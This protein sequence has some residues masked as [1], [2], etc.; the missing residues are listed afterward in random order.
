MLPSQILLNDSIPH[1]RVITKNNPSPGRIYLAPINPGA[2]GITTQMIIADNDGN[3]VF[4]KKP[5]SVYA[6][7][8]KL[9]PTGIYTYFDEGA[10]KYYGFKSL[11]YPTVT[12]SFQAI[13][14]YVT[15]N[16]ELRLLSNGGYVLLA[17][18]TA[19]E[20]I[21]DTVSYGNPKTILLHY[22]IQEFNASDSLVFIWNT[23]DHFKVT[24][25][26]HELLTKD[27]TVKFIDYAHCNSIET[28]GDTAY[29]LSSRNMDEITKISRSD[30]RIIWR[31]GGKHN[32]FTI[33]GDS[34]F[35]HQHFVS[36]LSNGN[37]LMFDNGNF[38]PGLTSYSR[39]VEFKIDEQLKTATKVW[40]FRHTPDVFAQG[41]GSAQR[42]A[43]GNTLIGWGGYLALALTEVRPDGSTALEME[44]TDAT[45]GPVFYSYRAVKDSQL[46][47]VISDRTPSMLSLGQNY[48]NP[49]SITTTI[50]FT[51]GESGPLT[52][53]LYDILGR[54]VKVLFDNY[55]PA[56]EFGIKFDCHG[57]RSGTYY[58]KIYTAKQTL[59]RIMTLL[60]Q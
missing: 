39:A 18:D 1:I 36:R 57:L 30:G 11:K 2:N 3:I 34:G 54:E 58:Y 27:S 37:I 31:F 44:M 21:A 24:D 32:Q 60:I 20:N 28:D 29:I 45:G 40:E 6:N 25:A 53:A 10:G 59:S 5:D 46:Q 33:L 14:G 51:I 35:S 22:S 13:K 16:H 55:L 49:C 19:T 8:F 43:N 15:D 52:L 9:Q 17:T 7:D 41:A 42:L 38:G 23:Q 26:T 56:G 4:Q 50:P 47:D 48:P 12:D